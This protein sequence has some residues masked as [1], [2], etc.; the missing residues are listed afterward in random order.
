MPY[1]VSM[2]DVTD[3]VPLWVYE[4][5]EI[6]PYDPRWSLVLAIESARLGI[7]GALGGGRRG[8]ACRIDGGPRASGQ[9]GHRPHGPDGRSRRRGRPRWRAA[10]CGRL[11]L[12]ATRLGPAAGR[13][14][15]VKPDASGQHRIAHLHVIRAGHPRWSEQIAF[16]D[17]LRRDGELASRYEDLKWWLSVRH[18]DDRESYTEAKAAFI[19]G[20]LA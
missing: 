17:A 7:S 9:A 10:R 20:A 8:G 11:V 1:V 6:H 4:Q 3:A 5:P 13:R 19:A 15:F 18:A 12:C 16:R 2:S 14:F